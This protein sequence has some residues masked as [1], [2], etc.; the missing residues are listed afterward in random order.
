MAEPAAIV[1][2]PL[3]GTISDPVIPDAARWREGMIAA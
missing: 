3:P 1:A 2:I